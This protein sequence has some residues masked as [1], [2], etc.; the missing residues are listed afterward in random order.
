MRGGRGRCELGTLES[1]KWRQRKSSRPWWGWR[2]A[3]WTWGLL[4]VEAHCQEGQQ[5]HEDMEAAV[6]TLEGS[7][8]WGYM[9]CWGLGV[10]NDT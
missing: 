7:G 6:S 8:G 3:G 2:G 5:L 9:R 4:G 1:R 10:A